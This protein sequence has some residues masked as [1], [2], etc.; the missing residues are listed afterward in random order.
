MNS[1]VDCPIC[2]QTFA[3]NKY[4]QQHVKAKLAC[5][6]K[7][8]KC[9][10]QADSKVNFYRHV[11]KCDFKC[12]TCGFQSYNRYDFSAHRDMCALEV[13]KV[14]TPNIVNPMNNTETSIKKRLRNADLSDKDRNNT[15]TSIKKRLRNADLSDKDRKEHFMYFYGK[16]E[17]DCVLCGMNPVRRFNKG[18]EQAHIVCRGKCPDNSD[19][20]YRVPMCTSCN[21]MMGVNNMFDFIVNRHPE[22][23]WIITMKLFSLQRGSEISSLDEVIE[24]IDSKYNVDNN[25]KHMTVIE[26]S[27][28]EHDAMQNIEKYVNTL[29]SM[30]DPVMLKLLKMDIP[31]N[32]HTSKIIEK[33]ISHLERVIGFV[34]RKYEI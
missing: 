11:K 28:R 18:H 16:E 4:Y 5:D 33:N 32:G 34:K 15:E 29:S 19:R 17:S 3:A 26:R 9:E 14:Y 22:K 23:L 6:L 27:L 12:I 8:K 13:N 20:S 2:K 31:V 24:F 21:S 30:I 1:R 7:C 25:I 10:F